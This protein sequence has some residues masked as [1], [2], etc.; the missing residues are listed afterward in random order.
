MKKV[1]FIRSNSINPDPRVEKEVITLLDNGYDVEILGWDRSRKNNSSYNKNLSNKNVKVYLLGSKSSFGAGFKKNFFPLLLFEIKLFI[2]LH[3]NILEFDYI[4]ACDFDTAYISNKLAKKF[5]KIFIYDIFDFY[6]DS[7]SV[8]N[9]LKKVVKKLDFRTINTSDAVILCTEERKDQ[10]FG[11]TPPKISI[12]HNSP[13]IQ[14][15]RPNKRFDNRKIN[16]VYAGI[17]ADHRFLIELSEV[18]CN[19]PNIV[20]HIAGFGKYYNYFESLSKVH[21]N[22]IFYGKLTYKDVLLLESQADL[23]IAFY[24][25]F[26]ANHKFSAPNKLYESMFL[27]NKI[28]VSKNSGIDGLVSMLN[29]GYIIE[30]NKEALRNFLNNLPKFF[31]PLSIEEKEKISLYYKSNYSWDIMEERLL[32]LYSILGNEKK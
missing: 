2:W 14:F 30:Y 22:I 15:L 32:K 5:N 19:N 12:I 13:N 3:K 10:I 1:L 24:S 8:P 31:T 25:P 18:V 4:H 21:S 11:S 16:L 27:P 17:L 28:L 23:I 26:I 9:V 29:L 7:F 6:V 20:L